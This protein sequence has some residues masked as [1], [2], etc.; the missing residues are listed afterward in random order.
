MKNGD[1]VISQCYSGD[2]FQANLNSKYQ[3]LV[4]MVPKEGI[5]IWTDNMI[6]PLHAANP[7]DALTCMDYFYS[8]ITQ[9]V[10][11]Y[12][13]D[14]I[15]PVPDAKAQLLH[16]TGWNKAALKAMD[17]EIQLPTSV[18]A[19]SLDVFP[20]AARIKASLPYYP[21]KNQDEITAWTNLF[22]PIIQGA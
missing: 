14:Y 17:A 15:C 6:I 22:L 3:D 12:Y 5:M 7:L 4:L 10:V 21:F 9:S 8:P 13:N 20:D 1:V 18:T 19:D 16:P 11:E 2:I